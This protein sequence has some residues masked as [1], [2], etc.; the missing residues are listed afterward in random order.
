MA[1][2]PIP[3]LI[4]IIG[5]ALIANAVWPK[6]VLGVFQFKRQVL[7]VIERDGIQ[8]FIG[9]AFLA[10]VFFIVLTYAGF[11]DRDARAFP[12]MRPATPATPPTVKT[13][14]TTG[15]EDNSRAK[16]E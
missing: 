13:A 12:G 15:S 6:L 9:R 4:V 8:N 5:S 16:A 2:S 10:V 11:G 1:L 14:V 3:K 7:E